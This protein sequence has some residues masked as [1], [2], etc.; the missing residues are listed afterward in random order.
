MRVLLK[1]A[2]A[3]LAMHFVA[4][5][6]NAQNSLLLTTERGTRI[7]FNI[8]RAKVENI[9]GKI[10]ISLL[11]KKAKVFEINGIPE[12]VFADTTLK[13]FGT[14]AVYITDSI[15]FKSIAERGNLFEITCPNKKPKAPF[16]L[17]ANGKMYQGKKTIMYS[18]TFTGQL[19]A[20]QQLKTSQK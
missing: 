14:T 13:I 5:Q 16:T 1:I 11:S 10:N 7:Y 9:N 4:N 18:L 20:K 19:P 17:L 8:K 6:A 2:F 3:F 12:S 15:T